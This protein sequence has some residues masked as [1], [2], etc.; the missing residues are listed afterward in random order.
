M[1]EENTKLTYK[2]NTNA[3][4]S[5]FCCSAL[6]MFT[7]LIQFLVDIHMYTYFCSSIF[8]FITKNKFAV[9]CF[10]LFQKRHSYESNFSSDW[11]FELQASI[12]D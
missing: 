12:L 5:T 8:V 11:M 6:G 9:C 2:I 1:A 7:L 10:R 4:L 3:S